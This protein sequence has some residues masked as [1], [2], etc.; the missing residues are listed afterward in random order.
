MALTLGVIA[1]DY[2]GASDLANALTRNGLATVQTIGVPRD[3]L[4]LPPVD[5]VVV[6]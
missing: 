3:D 6:A 1:D 2:T 5:A 4:P